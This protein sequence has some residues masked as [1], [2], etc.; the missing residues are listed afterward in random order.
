MDWA[1]IGCC[2]VAAICAI[3]LSWACAGGFRALRCLPRAFKVVFVS[4]AFATCGIAQK[5]NNVPQNLNQ[6][7]PPMQQGGGPFQMGLPGLGNLLN[8]ANPVQTTSDDVARGWRVESVT[9]NAA[10]SY[11][12]PTNATLVGNFHVH[13]VASSF[14]NNRLMLASI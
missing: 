4:A 1:Y 11:A 10:V 13:G 8:L 3:V 6:P 5:T 12:M 9:T 7:L 2:T 14:G